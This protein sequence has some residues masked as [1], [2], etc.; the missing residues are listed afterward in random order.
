MG[1]TSTRMVLRDLPLAARLVLAAF[2][3]SVGIGYCAALVQLH[4]QHAS[5]GSMLPTG[6]DAVRIFHGQ[7]ERPVSKIEAVLTADED[8]PFTGSGQMRSAFTKRSQG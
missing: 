6:D 2:L 1:N 7:T 8:K 5:P 3:I 4:F